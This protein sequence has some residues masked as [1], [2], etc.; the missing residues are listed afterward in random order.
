MKSFLC[1]TCGETNPE[2]FHI[3]DKQKNKNLCRACN[4]I[5]Y[6]I[7]T[8]RKN[9][10]DI[11]GFE[12]SVYTKNNNP[13][14]VTCLKHN[15]DFSVLATTLLRR[16]KRNGGK[17]K[18]PVVGSCPICREEYFINIRDKQIEKC[19]KA[20]NYEYE[21]DIN[22]YIN[23]S[24]PITVI[25]KKHGKFNIRLS[26]HSM[27]NGKCPKCVEEKKLLKKN[28]IIIDD[29][30]YFVCEKHGR[31][32]ITKKSERKTCPKCINEE[33]KKS[34]LNKIINRFDNDYFI[35]PN[36]NDF[37]LI[38]KK[39]GDVITL[40]YHS[41]ITRKKDKYHFCV[42]CFHERCYP[43]K[44]QESRIKLK[45]KI[46]NIINTDYS[47][48]YTF[49]DIIYGENK[50]KHKVVLYCKNRKIK[51]TVTTQLVLCKKLTKDLNIINR[52]FMPYEKAKEK[53]KQLNITSFSQ[54]KKW[55]KRTK[56]TEL[57]S[58]PH[59][60]YKEWVSHYDFF[61]KDIIDSMSLGE[62]KI[63]R[64][65]KRNEYSYIYE[66]KFDDCKNINP[67]RF[68]FYITELNTLIEFDGKQHFEPTAFSSKE[69]A[70]INYEYIKRNDEIKNQYCLDNNIYLIRL[71][72]HHLDNNL[73][74]WFLDEELTKINAE[75]AVQ[76]L[77]NL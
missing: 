32:P 73:I 72:H 75:I 34:Y 8:V 18:N 36:E 62:K 67:L 45:N 21:Y 15:H 16:T 12:K 59:R 65:L 55:H 57:P 14:T 58:N 71:D 77:K 13:I 40:P 56:Q 28:R 46:V 17:A 27:G 25:C 64:Y 22:S 35:K 43:N 54:Y 20:H 37:S 1:K 4:S 6:F 3:F 26:T 11:Y 33:H 31:F 30:Y 51:K 42:K 68:D 23:A 53:M 19:R 76:N 2:N 5:T 74:E 9:H 38:C 10:G 49:V 44:N 47:E 50:N 60:T 24:N 41:K 63:E 70:H 7:D 61:N 52:K 66:H 48:L 69:D 39:H 29:K